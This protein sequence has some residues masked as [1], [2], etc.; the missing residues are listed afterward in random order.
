MDRRAPS[1]LS[2]RPAGSRGQTGTGKRAGFHRAQGRSF[3]VLPRKALLVVLLHV[4]TGKHPLPLN[5]NPL[6]APGVL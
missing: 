5:K 3:L 1:S 2:T 4:S 6:G